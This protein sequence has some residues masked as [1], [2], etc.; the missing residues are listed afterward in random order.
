[1][2]QYL[3]SCI[4]NGISIG[5]LVR[6]Y[7]YKNVIKSIYI[8]AHEIEAEQQRFTLA[9]E[10]A[11]RELS[12]SMDVI[13]NL[14]GETQKFIIEPQIMMLDDTS[15]VDSIS[16]LI[17]DQRYSLEYSIQKF[18]EKIQTSFQE[19]RDAYLRE[20]MSDVLAVTSLVLKNAAK[21]ALNGD[22]ATGFDSVGNDELKGAI[23]YANDIT[24]SELTTLIAGGI[25]G[26]VTANTSKL[27]HTAIL[28]KSMEIPLISG[29]E[30]G[31]TEGCLALM[32]GFKGTFIIDP[33]E[34][35]LAEYRARQRN[36]IRFKALLISSSLLADHTDVA[37]YG[38]VEIPAEA[39]HL[40][41]YNARGI[42]LLRSE[43]MLLQMQRYPSFEE[44]RIFYRSI[45]EK[46][47]F[48][49][50]TI[51]TFD[52]GSDKVADFMEIPREENPAMGNRG[53]R[54]SLSNREAFV[55][56]LKAIISMSDCAEIQL[57]LP[58]VTLPEEVKIALNLIQEAKRQLKSEGFT[59][60]ERLPVGIMVETPA[61]ALSIGAFAKYVDF[62]SIGTNDLVQYTM[63]SDRTSRGVGQL[64]SPF[65][66]PVLRLLE[67]IAK[68]AKRFSLPVNVCGEAASD[69][70][71]LPILHG[72]GY[73]SFSV[74][75]P[76]IP[77]VHVMLSKISGAQ[78]ETLAQQILQC[79]NS[80]QVIAHAVE[81]VRQVIPA[82]L[83]EYLMVDKKC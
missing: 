79:W 56:H 78:S 54:Y 12:D 73:R 68:S 53:I 5:K 70:F 46:S 51:R 20:R 65:H 41:Q 71:Y 75:T 25:I 55:T 13:V 6:L 82:E 44:Q 3:G 10:R 67:M 18:N 36:L 66:P 35:T 4:S 64:C 8:L 31:E 11:R 57:L 28:C 17:R 2:E 21:I 19:V 43:F 60:P 81:F 15:F 48:L 40:Q 26:A 7:E 61:C 39:M 58:M 62:L 37:L 42:G 76:A 34:S 63:A 72:L 29:V 52:I 69:I 47:N 16:E 9:R 59:V 22:D 30:F 49:P 45:L 74:R 50:A 33:D 77:E 80:E 23:V 38:N 27:S 83:I 1:M 24:P 32:D 14:L